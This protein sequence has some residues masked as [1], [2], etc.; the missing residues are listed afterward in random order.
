[1]QSD[2]TRV[3]PRPV[4]VPRWIVTCSRICVRAPTSQRVGS[5]RYFRSC[6]SSPTVQNG[7][8]IAASPILVCPST[9]TCDTSRTPSS[10][11]TSGPTWHHGPIRTP[12]PSVARGETTAEGWISVPAE[13]DSNGAITAVMRGELSRSA[14]LVGAGGRAANTSIVAVCVANTARHPTRPDARMVSIATAA[15]VH[16]APITRAAASAAISAAP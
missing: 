5:P 6:G 7:N 15:P 12:R 2:P 1:M 11:T 10:S 13:G 14:R 16:T 4:T 8:R 3:R 9:T